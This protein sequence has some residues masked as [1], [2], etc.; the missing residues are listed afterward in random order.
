MLLKSGA[1]VLCADLENKAEDF[2]IS[3]TA[4]DKFIPVSVDVRDEKEVES[5]VRDNIQT[6]GIPDGLV[7]LTR[8]IHNF[9]P[10]GPIITFILRGARL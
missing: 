1:N 4:D 7:I 5:F 10:Y 6:D 9:S 3:I 8:K 2:G